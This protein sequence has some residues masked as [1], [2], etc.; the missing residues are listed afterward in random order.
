FREGYSCLSVVCPVNRDTRKRKR[1]KELND[2]E[3]LIERYLDSWCYAVRSGA[4][5]KVRGVAADKP[6]PAREP[7]EVE[8]IAIRRHAPRK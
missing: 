7:A 2:E 3:L 6:L 8:R 4:S 5:A 1:T